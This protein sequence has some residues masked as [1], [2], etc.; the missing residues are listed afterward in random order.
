[1]KLTAAIATILFLFPVLSYGQPRWSPS[2]RA[3]RE[4]A[5]MRDSLH[6]SQNALSKVHEISLVYNQRMD[7]VNDTHD[8][9]K[10][11]V[12]HRL[13]RK[14]NRAIRSLLTHKQYRRYYKREKIIREKEKEIYSSGRR[15]E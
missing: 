1:M 14:K 11:R 13:T 3:D 10:N 12:K 15:P 8:R 7:S 9:R 5:W 4:T 6:L 2:I